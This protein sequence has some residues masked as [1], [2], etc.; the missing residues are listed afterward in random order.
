MTA[1][2]EGSHDRRVIEVLA[3]TVNDEVRAGLAILTG[4]EIEADATSAWKTLSEVGDVEDLVRARKITVEPD[5]DLPEGVDGLAL[6]HVLVVRP[7]RRRDLWV[8]RVLHELAHHILGRKRVH[9][10]ADVWRLT[11][12]LAWPL[13]R[14]RKGLPC[15]EIPPW[16]EAM[17]VLCVEESRMIPAA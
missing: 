16:A 8:L 7:S 3:Q 12:A 4:H 10:H 14:I 1:A 15:L 6:P 2:R 5:R 9:T 17:R 11:L 13:H